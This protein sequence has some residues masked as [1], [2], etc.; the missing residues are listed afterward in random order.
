MITEEQ[1]QEMIDECSPAVRIGGRE[2][3]A[4][5]ALRRIDP[6]QFNIEYHDYVQFLEEEESA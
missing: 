4:G 6:V 1:Y 5:T 3:G 2:Y